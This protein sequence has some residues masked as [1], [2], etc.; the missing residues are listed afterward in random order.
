MEKMDTLA[1]KTALL[2]AYAKE[3]V[4]N[5]SR[6]WKKEEIF[7]VPNILSVVR[8]A[9]IPVFLW[10]Y[11]K[12]QEYGWA[13]GIVVLSGITDILDGF[14]ARRWNMVSDLGK[15]LD[16]AADKLTQLALIVS[17]ALRYRAVGHLLGLFVLKELT[18]GVLGLLVV[19][20]TR[21]VP[22][23]RWFGKACTAVLEGSMGA[24][25]LFPNLPMA[26]VEALTLVSGCM[27]AFAFV[28][29]VILDIRLLQTAGKTKDA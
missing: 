15:I 18:M 12:K 4:N 8:L 1:I 24:L 20:K 21:M 22:S 9:L 5:M 7:T 23:A 11:C 28:Q 29:Y 13:A 16:P 6:Q 27:L 10:L 3:A 25:I 26:A 17:L 2:R 14:I 19:L